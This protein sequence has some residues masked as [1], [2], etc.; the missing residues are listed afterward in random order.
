MYQT[1]RGKTTDLHMVFLQVNLTH[2]LT[3]PFVL[4]IIYIYIPCC[5]PA[6]CKC[7]LNIVKPGENGLKMLVL[8]FYDPFRLF[9]SVVCSYTL[10]Y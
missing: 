5:A 9:E 8:L 4:M 6:I 10:V 7:S 2:P 3:I 1:L